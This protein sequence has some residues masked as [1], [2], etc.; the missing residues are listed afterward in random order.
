MEYD[1]SDLSKDRTVSKP[2]PVFAPVMKTT[3]FEE[4]ISLG[5]LNQTFKHC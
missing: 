1:L 4:D 5:N 2:S 3:L